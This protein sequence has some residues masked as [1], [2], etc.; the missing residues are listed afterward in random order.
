[1]KEIIEIA[2]ALSDPNRV[3]ALMLLKRGEFCVCQ[4]VDFLKLSPSTVSKHMSILKAAGII[5]CRK[6]DKWVYYRIADNNSSPRVKEIIQWVSKHCICT[7]KDGSC[8]GSKIP[9][10]ITGKTC[11]KTKR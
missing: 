4:I 9:K 11:Q 6:D 2:K 8:C 10:P 5:E 1:M 7:S 3:K